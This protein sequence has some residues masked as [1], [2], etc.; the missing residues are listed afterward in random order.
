VEALSEG[1]VDWEAA[2][3]AERLNEVIDAASIDAPVRDG[4][5]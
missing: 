5:G 2:A 4:G 3:T 1:T